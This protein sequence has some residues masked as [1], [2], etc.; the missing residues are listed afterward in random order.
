MPKSINL[1]FDVTGYVEQEIT[2]TDPNMTP[3][4]LLKLLKEG[5]AATTIQ[6]NGTVDYIADGVVIG[7]VTSVDNQCEYSDYELI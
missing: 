3:E 4:K 6:E 2:V 7:T 5:K 1:R